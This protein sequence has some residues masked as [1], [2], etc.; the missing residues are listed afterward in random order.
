MDQHHRDEL[1]RSATDP[2]HAFGVQHR[3]E[4]AKIRRRQFPEQSLLHGLHLKTEAVRQSA[5]EQRNADQ[6]SYFVELEL[7]GIGAADQ[8]H[9]SP[10][11]P[12]DL[13]RCE[14]GTFGTDQ[15]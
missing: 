11:E 9:R 2:V 1:L 4:Q 14:V 15:V 3:Q 10:A 5:V 7:I 12:C 13:E 8:L 6:G